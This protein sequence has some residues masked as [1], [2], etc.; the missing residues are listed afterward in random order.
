MGTILKEV[1][2]YSSCVLNR[3][4]MGLLNFSFCLHTW[5]FE[6]DSGISS[7]QD[8]FPSKVFVHL[9]NAA[10]AVAALPAGLLS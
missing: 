8:S 9:R 10:R 4:L 6:N 7:K 3:S 2:H 1:W 5:E